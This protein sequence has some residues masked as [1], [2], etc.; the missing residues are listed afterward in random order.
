MRDLRAHDVEMVTIGQYPAALARA[1]PVAALLDAE[2]FKALEDYGN[3]LGFSHVASGPMVRSSYHADRSRPPE[4]QEGLGRRSSRERWSGQPR[5]SGGVHRRRASAARVAVNRRGSNFRHC[6]AVRARRILQPRRPT[7]VRPDEANRPRLSCPS[8]GPWQL[9]VIKR[10]SRVAMAMCCPRRRPATRRPPRGWYTGCPT[11]ATPTA[12]A[13]WTMPRRGRAALP[14]DAGSGQGVPD[15]A[16]R[17][18]VSKYATKLDDAIKSGQVDPAWRCS[19]CT[20]SG[21]VSANARGC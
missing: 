15:R 21:S 20:G 3:A 5:R 1:P 10:C 13:R 18:P 16:G 6:R 9:P 8:A 12:R 11:V 4:L 19:A 7:P 17:W 2:E 14:G